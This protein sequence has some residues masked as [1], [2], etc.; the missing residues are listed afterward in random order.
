M[1]SRLKYIITT[2]TGTR[3]LILFLCLG[4]QNLDQRHKL[5]LLVTNT[6]PLPTGFLVGFSIAIGILSGGCSAALYFPINNKFKEETED[7]RY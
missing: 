7:N 4:S 6:A 2:L 3:L 5:N 1:L